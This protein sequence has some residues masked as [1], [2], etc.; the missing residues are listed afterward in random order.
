MDPTSLT[1]FLIFIVIVIIAV[2]VYI[3]ENGMLTFNPYDGGDQPPLPPGF[4][5]P[6]NQE[7]KSKEEQP[8]AP[9]E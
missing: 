7:P 5:E 9:P 3:Y 8:P 1:L 6:V 2:G 4:K